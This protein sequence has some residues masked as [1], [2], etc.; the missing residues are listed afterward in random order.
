MVTGS[1]EYVRLT[2]PEKVFGQKHLLQS[3]LELLDSLQHLR[4]FKLLRG[5]EFVLKIALKSKIGEALETISKFEKMLPS[6]SYRA[7]KRKKDDDDL[8]KADRPLTL[9]DEIDAIRRKLQM[10]H[11]NAW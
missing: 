10:L 11:K 5:E 6:T 4:N 3:Q 8:H 1:S 2:I 7:V 9:Q